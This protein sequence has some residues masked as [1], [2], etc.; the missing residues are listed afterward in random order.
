MVHFGIDIGVEAIFARAFAGPGGAGRLLGKA[1][2]HDGFDALEAV[3]PRYDQSQRRTVL[4]GQFLAIQPGRQQGK[5]VH[6][7]VHAQS[8]DVG[9]VQQAGALSRHLLRVEQGGELDVLGA[10]GWLEA[11]QNFVQWNA[12]PRYHH[13]PAF[14]AAQPVDAFLGR[15]RGQDIF[16]RVLARFFAMAFD[17]HRPGLGFQTTRVLGQ[18][19]LAEAEFVEVVVGREVLVGRRFEIVVG[20]CLR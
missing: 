7:L 20:G 1:D 11:R 2:F 12:Q 16:Q 19:A 9:P 14:H 5:R 10:G 13:G 17:R 4:R 8:L 15:V 6:G 3:F 18:V